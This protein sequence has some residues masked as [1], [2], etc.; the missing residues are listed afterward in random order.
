M[1]F[2]EFATIIEEVKKSHKAHCDAYDALNG[3]AVFLESDLTYL[4][5]D[6]LEKYFGYE[7]EWIKYWAFDLEWGECY[8]SGDV[9]ED[10]GRFIR[11]KTIEDLYCLLTGNPVYEESTT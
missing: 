5:L 9:R 11:L 4:A 8:E 7:D 10:D 2:E 6:L 1:K 3:G